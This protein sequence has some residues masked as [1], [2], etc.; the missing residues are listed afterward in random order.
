MTPRSPDLT[1][2][3]FFLWGFVKDEVYA[4]KPKTIEVLKE[5]THKVLK[6]KILIKHYVNMYA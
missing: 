4:T 1:S 6:K 2:M 3:D 5:A